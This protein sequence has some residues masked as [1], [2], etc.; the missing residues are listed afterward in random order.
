GR[1]ETLELRLAMHPSETNPYLLTRVIAYCLNVQEGIEFTQ[2]IASPE[3]PA[4]QVK[5]LTGAVQL[6]IEIGNPSARRL[7]K[8]SKRVRV[9]T[10]RDPTILQQEVKGE[11]IHRI[12]TIE[13]FSLGALFLNRLSETLDRDNA[14]EVLHNG[15]E[16]AIT[17]R[18]Q[19]SHGEIRQTCLASA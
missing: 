18:G 16:L 5:D 11:K 10:Y 13:V 19:V 9:Y 14:W 15:G 4:L 17:V 7:H 1:Y 8:A 6:W 2:G 12:E 3:E